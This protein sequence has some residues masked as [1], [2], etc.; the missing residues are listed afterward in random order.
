[1]FLLVWCPGARA[2]PG[3]LDRTPWKSGPGATSLA[4]AW[5]KRTASW[6]LGKTWLR[7]RHP[8]S[9]TPPWLMSSYT[10]A[11]RR[12][13]PPS[14]REQPSRGEAGV[15]AGGRPRP[16]ERGVGLA[17]SVPDSR[18]RRELADAEGNPHLK[19]EGSCWIWGV[20]TS[21]R[22]ER[23]WGGLLPVLSPECPYFLPA[24]F[25]VSQSLCSSFCT[26]GTWPNVMATLVVGHIGILVVLS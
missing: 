24:L 17:I 21:P 18:G 7:S 20:S 15:G 2:A 14:G 26:G 1:M 5:A 23:G 22:F 13:E 4:F 8:S 11:A 25:R 16:S 19:A 9:K 6:T 10:W 12:E 3:C